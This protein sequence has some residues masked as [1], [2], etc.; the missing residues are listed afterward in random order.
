MIINE[1]FYYTENEPKLIDL[2]TYEKV[3]EIQNKN[4]SWNKKIINNIKT[5]VMDN[6]IFVAL[7]IIGI[8]LLIL[9]YYYVRNRKKK[10]DVIYGKKI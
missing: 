3:I 7:I 6:V 2:N 4:L 1:S 10:Y 9:R 5:F 8:I